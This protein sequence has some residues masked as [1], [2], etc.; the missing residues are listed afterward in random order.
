MPLYETPHRDHK[1]HLCSLVAE[2]IDLEDYRMHVRNPRFLCRVCG[3]AAAEE[4]SLCDP[5]PL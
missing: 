2:G 5:I 1:K 3:R 4:S